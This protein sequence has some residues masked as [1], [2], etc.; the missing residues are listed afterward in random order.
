MSRNDIEDT[1]GALHVNQITA[2]YAHVSFLLLE[3]GALYITAEVRKQ[4]LKEQRNQLI[5]RIE[6]MLASEP[7][8]TGSV[9]SINLIDTLQSIRILK[10]RG[11]S[12][13]NSIIL[14]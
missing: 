7:G 9:L 1:C 13:R 5:A 12:N 10:G 3:Q 2:R 14:I 11:H 8:S 4:L 6:D